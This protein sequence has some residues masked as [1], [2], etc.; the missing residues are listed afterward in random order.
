VNPSR[1]GRSLI[2]A[3]VVLIVMAVAGYWFANWLFSGPAPPARNGRDV[4][5]PFLA[6]IRDGRADEAW[7]S[8]T[9]EFKSAEGRESFRER[10]RHPALQHELDFVSYNETEVS[11]LTRGEALYRTPPDVA[12]AAEVSLLLAAEHGTWKIEWI[13]ITE[14]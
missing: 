3:L 2:L 7:E 5:E 13:A 1:A 8:T 10:A 14:Q 4:S 9:A 12:P 11:G 6:A